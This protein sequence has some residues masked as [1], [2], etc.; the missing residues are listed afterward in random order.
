M[1]KIFA[2]VKFTKIFDHRNLELHGVFSSA[3]LGFL[4][5]ESISISLFVYSA[6]DM[7]QLRFLAW[8]KLASI[9]KPMC[10][11]CSMF[12]MVAITLLFYIFS[13]NIQHNA[14]TILFY[15]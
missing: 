13:V 1:A 11:K 9:A 10:I 14:L 2:I 12:K 8:I 5:I 6:Y 7:Q 4:I 15:L 3:L